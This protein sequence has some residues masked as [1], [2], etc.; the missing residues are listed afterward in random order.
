MPVCFIIGEAD[1][2]I[3]AENSLNQT[4][5]ANTAAIHILPKVGHMGMFEAQLKT[6]G[7]IKRF[8]EFSVPV[9]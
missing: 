5:L 1:V 6:V 2:A 3:P 9:A 4:F 7:I 8:I